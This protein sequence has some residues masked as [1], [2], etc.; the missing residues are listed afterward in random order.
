M[1]FSIV[2]RCADTGMFGV[3]VSSSSI[4]VA[5]RCA[6]TRAGIGAASSQN[7]TDPSL[8]T[9][10]LDMM[11]LGSNAIQT[12][13]ILRASRP[14]MEYRQV[15]IVD[16]AGVSAIHSGPKSL[17]VW[18]QA[19]A[20]NVACGGNLLSDPGVPQAMVDAFLASRGHIAERLLIALGAGLASGGEAG[21]VRS[22][23]LKIVDKVPWPTADLRVDWTD[24][25]PIAELH[26]LWERYSPQ[27][28]D[29][30]T[31]ALNPTAAPSYGVPGNL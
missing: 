30:V 11:S 19:H 22:A 21:P 17:G 1:T 12:I 3:A 7:V 4:A 23:G 6:H 10:A 14:H 5:S 27:L 31:R 28:D 20:Q 24:G 26:A 25:C 9:A 15:L 2:A 8:G 13:D 18:A 16:S 29:Y